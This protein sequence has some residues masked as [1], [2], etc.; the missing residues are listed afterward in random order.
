V[1]LALLCEKDANGTV[2]NP[3]LLLKK[4]RDGEVGIVFR[5]RVVEMGV[6]QFGRTVTSLVIEWRPGTAAPRSPKDTWRSSKVLEK[7]EEAF[8]TARLQSSFDFNPLG[9]ETVR[10]TKVAALREAFKVVYMPRSDDD[11]TKRRKAT[12]TAQAGI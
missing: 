8:E 3:R 2:S 1:T 10:A 5:P 11:P 12:E 9:V 6:N 4:R 7:F